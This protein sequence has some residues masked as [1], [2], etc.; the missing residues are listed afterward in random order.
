MSRRKMYILLSYVSLILGFFIYVLFRKNSYIGILFGKFQLVH[1]VREL[2]SKLSCDFLKFYLTDY[3]WG[4]S[5]CCGLLAIYVPK[6]SGCML[7]SGTAFLC[8]CIWEWMQFKNLFNGTGDICDVF[9][10]FLA[11]ITCLIINIRSERNEKN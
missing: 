11:S 3:L 6:R 10:Y 1:I 8:G 9:M 4:F 2:T 5:L 7:C